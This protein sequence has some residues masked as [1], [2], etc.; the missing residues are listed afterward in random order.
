MLFLDNIL[1]FFEC[2]EEHIKKFQAIKYF[3]K[4][5]VLKTFL[6]FNG[7]TDDMKHAINP[8]GIEITSYKTKAI[9]TL[10]HSTSYT[11]I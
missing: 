9:N 6:H 1:V 11:V 3:T 4:K 8:E 5:V 2:L 7:K 10:E